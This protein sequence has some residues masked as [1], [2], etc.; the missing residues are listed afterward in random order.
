MKIRTTNIT[1]VRLRYIVL[2]I[3]VYTFKLK[4]FPIFSL[5]KQKLSAMRQQSF[6]LQ[7]FFF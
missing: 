5:E 1:G 7:Y 4:D 6:F 3:I 2:F